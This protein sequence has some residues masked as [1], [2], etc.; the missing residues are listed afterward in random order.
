MSGVQVRQG[1]D[2]GGLMS[3]AQASELI[4]AGLNLAIGGAQS[5]LLSLP[6]GR[7]IGGTTPYFMA[8]EG[9]VCSQDKVFVQ[10]LGDG[11]ANVINYDSD[12]LA[13]VL[14]DAPE[15]GYSIIILPAGSHILEEYARH[16]PNLPDMYIK[17]IAGWVAGVHV[18][19]IG[20]ADAAVVDG[21]T[22]S[23]F[24]DRAVVL[25]VPLADNETV[26]VHTVNVFEAGDG[27]GVQF[28][29]TGFSA[30]ACLIDGEPGNLAQAMRNLRIDHRLP[31]VADYCG[32]LLNVSIQAV[33]EATET[34]SFFAP[35]FEDVTYHFAKPMSNYPEQFI[36]AM[37]EEKGTVLFGCNC[38]LNYLY[39][40]L[41]GRKTAGLTGPITFGE[42]AYQLLNQ[43]AVYLILEQ[44]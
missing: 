16:A 24:H 20:K 3:V 41:E 31:L 35:I 36:A 23:L 43:T 12:R 32:A 4:L 22:G 8:S 21:T 11:P 34:V 29:E 10:C 7:W 6:K 39:S 28:P 19:D 26:T 5:L 2:C 1:S 37:G 44:T 30:G 33:D 14:E 38:I 15:E 17:P 13:Q 40:E 25:H 27:P 18:S 9:G 42:V